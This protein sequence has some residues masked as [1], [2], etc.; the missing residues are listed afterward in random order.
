MSMKYYVVD[1]FA[2]KVF[3]GNPAGVCILD[4][5]LPDDIMQKIAIENNLSETAFAVKEDDYYRLRWFTPGNEIDLCG[6]ATL[7]T[8]YVITNFYDA[9]IKRV[10]FQTLS[11]ELI[12]VKKGDLYEMDFPSRMPNAHQLTEQM[13]EAL[14]YKPTETYLGRDLMFVLDSESDVLSLDPNFAKLAALPDGL[15][16][17]VTAKSDQYDFVSRSFFPKLNVN[18]DLVCG[19]AHCNFIPYWAE[20]LNKQEMIARQVSKRGGTLYCKLLGERVTI[21]GQAVLYS[22]A[23]IFI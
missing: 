5:W 1:A 7:A 23:E 17:Q 19:S 15:G 22:I 2:N 14:G 16:V 4:E 18:E 8:A 3:E 21:S 13:V 6:H 10:R 9:E 12:V 20:R 11:G